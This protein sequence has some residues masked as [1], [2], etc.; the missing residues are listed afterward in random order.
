MEKIC[1]Y[2]RV[3]INT[4]DEELLHQGA[5]CIIYTM[6]SEGLGTVE[7]VWQAPAMF[8][9]EMTYGDSAPEEVIMP[10]ATRPVPKKEVPK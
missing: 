10:Y 6:G 7:A 1:S 4:P 8:D 2:H 9:G 5:N 3:K